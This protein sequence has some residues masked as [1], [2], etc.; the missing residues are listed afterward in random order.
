MEDCL[1][2]LLKYMTYTSTSIHKLDPN[3]SLFF[4]N[5]TTSFYFY[6]SFVHPFISAY[7]YYPIQLPFRPSPISAQHPKETKTTAGKSGVAQCSL[8]TSLHMH[9]EKSRT[10][11]AFCPWRSVFGRISNAVATFVYPSYCIIVPYFP[12][13]SS[14]WSRVSN[15]C[16]RATWK[17]RLHFPL[18]LAYLSL[19]L[20]FPKSSSLTSSLCLVI[21]VQPPKKTNIRSAL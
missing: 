16:S 2:Y 5:P 1:R 21:L 20:Q 10:Y 9:A 19:V 15:A 8:T 7:A 3:P 6:L 13:Q 18:K 14:R 12:D 4:F 17:S 11:M